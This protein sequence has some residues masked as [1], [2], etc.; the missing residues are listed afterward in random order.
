VPGIAFY[1]WYQD[2]TTTAE[3]SLTQ[4][5]SGEIYN[6]LYRL[7]FYTVVLLPVGI[8][9]ALSSRGDW[10][11]KQQLILVFCCLIFVPFLLEQ[12]LVI[13][14]GLGIRPL[15]IGIS[16]I[17]IAVIAWIVTPFVVLIIGLLRKV[18]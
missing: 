1:A 13:R 17:V 7:L 5:A 9:L 11:N 16:A 6:W 18:R 14:S 10:S 3:A 4:I 8:L 2:L 15:N 12:A